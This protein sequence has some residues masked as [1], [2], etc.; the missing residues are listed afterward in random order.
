MVAL[1]V[2][3]LLSPLWEFGPLV[4][5]GVLAVVTGWTRSW[6][7]GAATAAFFVA[8]LVEQQPVPAV[9]ALA[10]ALV[11]AAHDLHARRPGEWFP[12][13]VTG[14]VVAVGAAADLD[15]ALTV[16]VAVVVALGLGWWAWRA[17]SLVVAGTAAAYLALAWYRE[18]EASQPG[19]QFLSQEQFEAAFS[20]AEVALRPEVALFVGAALAYGLAHGWRDWVPLTFVVLGLLLA[21]G[22][23]S[24]P[25]GED[26]GWFAYEPLDTY[27]PFEVYAPAADALLAPVVGLA[28]AAVAL[29]LRDRRTRTP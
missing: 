14:V 16:L 8:A 10:G 2:V 6:R 21:V 22:P 27:E 20:T 4:G 26:F 29:V 15:P 9:V 28:G 18:P 19:M 7:L 1:A 12:L 23:S 11:I 3:G 24:Y 17:R 25:G 13:L 5:T